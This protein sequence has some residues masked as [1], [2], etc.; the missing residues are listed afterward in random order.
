LHA[1]DF[2]WPPKKTEKQL[3]ANTDVSKVVAH[4]AP[5]FAPEFAPE[6]AAAA[7]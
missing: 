6:L 2:G 3:I 5:E 4:I 1:E 7:A